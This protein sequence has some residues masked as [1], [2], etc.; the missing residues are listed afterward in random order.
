MDRGQYVENGGKTTYQL[1]AEKRDRFVR[2]AFAS[3]HLVS[4]L[5]TPD[6]LTFGGG[7]VAAD[8]LYQYDQPL[9]GRPPRHSGEFYFGGDDPSE[10]LED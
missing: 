2:A 7:G 4:P 9:V 1:E 8:I 10:Y 3:G 5:A 6:E